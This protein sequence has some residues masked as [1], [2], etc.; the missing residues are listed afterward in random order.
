MEEYLFGLLD[1]LVP[2]AKRD[3]FYQPVLNALLSEILTVLGFDS[4]KL[5]LDIAIL[6]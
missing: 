5:A 4:Y 3:R 2:L 6:Y 1:Q